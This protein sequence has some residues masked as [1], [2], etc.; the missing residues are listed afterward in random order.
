MAKLSVYQREVLGRLNKDNWYLELIRYEDGVLRVYIMS[1][2]GMTKNHGVLTTSRTY[3][4]LSKRGLIEPINPSDRKRWRIST[5]GSR[6]LK[7]EYQARVLAEGPETEY[8]DQ[9]GHY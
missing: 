2:T 8:T 3:H 7:M 1:N 5:V 6:V 4:V 9:H